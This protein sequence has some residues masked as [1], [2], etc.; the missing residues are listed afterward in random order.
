MTWIPIPKCPVS[1]EDEPGGLQG[2]ELPRLFIYS[3]HLAQVAML[4]L[5]VFHIAVSEA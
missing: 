4:Q 2:T 1:P 5:P 3:V